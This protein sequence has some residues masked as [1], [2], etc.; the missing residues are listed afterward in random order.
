MRY[1]FH[2]EARLEYLDAAAYYAAA[3]PGLG[4]EFS[5][6]IES[7]I[8]QICEAPTRWGFFEQ[9]VRRCLARRFPFAVLYSIEGDYL[10][11]VAIMHCSREPGYWRRRV[12]QNPPSA[13][14]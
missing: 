3:R 5:R 12:G 6:E 4:A 11:I 14:L 7:V 2:P 1:A 9:D 10:L 8:A 13:P